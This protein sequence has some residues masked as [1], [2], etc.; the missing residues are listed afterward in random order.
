MV[1]APIGAARADGLAD[2]SETH[3]K[4]TL[5]HSMLAGNVCCGYCNAMGIAILVIAH[6]RMHDLVVKGQLLTTHVCH[7]K[8][9]LRTPVLFHSADFPAPVSQF[10]RGEGTLD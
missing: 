8:A 5:P 7:R 2:R 6:F 9:D 4:P 3:G 1:A 10:K